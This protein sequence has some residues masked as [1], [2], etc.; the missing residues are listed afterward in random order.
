MTDPIRLMIQQAVREGYRIRQSI[1][2]NKFREIPS[3]GAQEA[4]IVESVTIAIQNVS[5]KVTLPMQAPLP[6]MRY[7]NLRAAR[8]RA[9]RHDRRSLLHPDC[10][11]YNTI[12]A[13]FRRHYNRLQREQCQ[14]LRFTSSVRLC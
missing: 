2:W 6:D 10:T 4:D 7:L 14:A 11:V 8:Y 12:S 9:Q 3:E 5:R 1:A 13:V